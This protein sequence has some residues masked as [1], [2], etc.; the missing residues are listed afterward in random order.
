M[1]VETTGYYIMDN[2]KEL[3]IKALKNTKGDDA[4]RARQAFSGLSAE[5]M[6]KEYGESGQSCAEIL[7]GYETCDARIDAAIDWVS[8]LEPPNE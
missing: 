7:A 1:L 4:C 3:I 8:S 2:L 5:D 6:Q